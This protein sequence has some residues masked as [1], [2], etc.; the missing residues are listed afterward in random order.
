MFTLFSH[1]REDEATWEREESLILELWI[2]SYEFPK[3]LCA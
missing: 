3:V 1:H 2:L